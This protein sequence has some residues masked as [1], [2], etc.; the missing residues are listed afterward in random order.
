[1]GIVPTT[2]G[3]DVSEQKSYEE[4]KEEAQEAPG[5]GMDALG[6]EDDDT[7]DGEPQSERAKK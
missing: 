1:M 3:D 2:K 7:V 6:V 4:A 5:E